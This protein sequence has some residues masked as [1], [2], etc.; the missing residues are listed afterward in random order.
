MI[1]ELTVSVVW[2]KLAAIAEEV[3]EAQQRTAYSDQVREGGD[4]STAVFDEQGRMLA[5]ANRSPAHLGSM[6]HAVTNLLAAYPPETLRPG[7]VVVLNDP[8]MGAG[9]LPDLF[10]MSPAFL[11]ERIV[12]Y[13]VSC[14]HLT[15]V[16]GP[17]PGSQAVVGVTDLVQ[18]GLRLPPTRIYREG[19]PVREVL[20][21]IRANV[22]VPD[23]VLGD[24]RAQRGALHVGV[25]K[26]T[27]LHRARDSATITEVADTLLA[28]SE[29]AVRAELSAIGNCRATFVDHIDDYGPGTP[30]IRIEVTVTICDGEIEFDFTGTDPQTPSSLNC[31]LSYA[32][33]YC[34]WATKAITTGDRI[35]QNAGQLR[36]VRVTAPAGSFFNPVPP[37]A[38]GG[39]ALMNQ[40]IVELLFGAFAQVLPDRVCAASGQWMNPIFGGSDPATGRPFIF[41]DYVMGGVGARATKDG[42]DAISSVVSVENIPVEAQEARNPIIVERY[43]LIPDSGGPGR[44]RGGLGVRKDVRVLADDV[45]LSNLTDR[46]VVPPWGLAG[47]SVG[48][49]GAT[50]L[51]PGTENERKLH[52]KETVR[53]AR[54]DLVSF[55]CSGSGGFGP[56][57]ERDP[58]L[59]D[60]DVR[61]GRVTPEAARAIYGVEVSDDS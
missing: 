43:E 25:T 3:A 52:S 33:A 48:T 9:H 12:G 26:L 13:V 5:Q 28:R 57:G 56:P 45:V 23:P 22:R 37:A 55:R 14:V 39:R 60:D 30:P 41:Y 18:E 58:E 16:G 54:D 11:D 27:E 59:V 36:P 21:L 24:I 10:A 29:A 47:G 8:Y 7:D 4:Y 35:P 51:N 15:D 20:E 32:R 34:Y 19:E 1:D 31:T 17:A 2:A 6:P 40:R 38:L 50:I 42:I 44:A 53:L 61:E 46:Q 49:L